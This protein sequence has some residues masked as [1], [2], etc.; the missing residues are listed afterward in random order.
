M[1]TKDNRL[2]VIEKLLNGCITY[3][4]STHENKF[5]DT[6]YR[7][8]KIGFSN[9]NVDVAFHRLVNNG[10]N[11]IE[12]KSNHTFDM[13]NEKTLSNV[14]QCEGDFYIVLFDS[15]DDFN[16]HKDLAN[17]FYKDNI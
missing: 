10:Y 5:G 7:F 1:E 4:L 15:I 13:F 2:M 16:R 9:Y 17:K 14:S 8:F 3:M 6:V 12:T 11:V